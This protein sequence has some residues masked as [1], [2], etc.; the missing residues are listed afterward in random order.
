MKTLILGQIPKNFS[1]DNSILIGPGCFLNKEN[2]YPNWENY[3]FE[4]DPASTKKKLKKFDDVT[5]S[6]S[7]NLLRNKLVK[8]LNDCNNSNYSY[9]FWKIVAF[10]WLYF[11]IQCVFERQERIK[12][13]LKK[14]SSSHLKV[15]LIKDNIQWEFINTLEF[16]SKGFNNPIF[17]E[18][19]YSRI[20]ENNI[21]KSWEVEY[22]DKSDKIKNNSDKPL[23]H[24]KS[25]NILISIFQN[26]ANR[27]PFQDK[28]GLR[29]YEQVIFGILSYIIMLLKNKHKINNHWDK[30]P[31][32]NYNINIKWLFEF[33]KILDNVIPASLTNINI[34][35]KLFKS[36]LYIISNKL[37][38]HDSLK[39]SLAFMLEK[40][41]SKIIGM[42]HG[43]HNYGSAYTFNIASEIEFSHAAFITWGWQ[44]QSNYC[45]N[46]IVLPSPNLSKTADKYKNKNEHLILVGNLTFFYS[47]S[48]DSNPQPQKGIKYLKYKIS[49]F[50]NVKKNIFSY[51]LYRYY[52]A[53]PGFFNDMNYIRMKF[54]NIK[55]LN[56]NF[57]KKILECKLLV[58]DHPSTTLNKAMSANIPT[59]CFWDRESWPMCSQAKPYYQSLRDVGILFNNGKEA[60]EKV[61]EI[62][63][64]V[65]EW[66]KQP[67]VQRARKN[68]AWQ[69]AR[70]SKHWRWEWIKF[71]WKI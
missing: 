18:W 29:L 45:G 71:L 69:Y 66:W 70:T 55:M 61:N 52:P 26:F 12:Q 33:N 39:A 34:V 50:N 19:L 37:L 30:S 10:P 17:N 36:K 42:Q 60:A 38:Y 47:Q 54:P 49:F 57:E 65:E 5:T 48:F 56:E 3:E 2:L 20:L 28:V 41:A 23:T 67:K 27:L 4:P 24:K 11:F 35:N 22:I 15:Y 53:P 16:T 44:E 51:I 68:W 58:L 59:I 7:K 1:P 8:Y 43:G 6:Y 14:Y 21:P 64:N 9:N 40:N 46:F 63:D 31:K 62:W 25:K 13:I 32:T